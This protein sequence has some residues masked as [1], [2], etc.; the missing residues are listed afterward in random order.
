MFIFSNILFVLGWFCFGSPFFCAFP[1]QAR[2]WFLSALVLCGLVFFWSSFFIFCIA[3][4]WLELFFLRSP[5]PKAGLTTHVQNMPW[6]TTGQPYKTSRLP[7][8]SFL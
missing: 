1:F 4:W 6:N 2:S 7:S 5:R 3:L 8:H